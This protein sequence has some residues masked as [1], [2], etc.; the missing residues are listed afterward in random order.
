MSDV[1]IV[2]R[3]GDGSHHSRIVNLLRLVDL[4]TPRISPSVEVAD[5]VDIL[6][7]CDDDIGVRKSTPTDDAT[8][9]SS[10][11]RPFTK[12]TF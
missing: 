5:I 6:L 9:V 1:E 11:V 8:L 2:V 12:D 7:D 3:L 10:G 4:V